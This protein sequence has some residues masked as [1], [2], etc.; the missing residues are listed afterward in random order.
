MVLFLSHLKIRFNPLSHYCSRVI[1]QEIDETLIAL[2][3]VSIPYHITVVGSLG[4]M[5]ENA[6]AILRFQSPITSQ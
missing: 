6:H 4:N 2:G 5:T 1:I 3:L